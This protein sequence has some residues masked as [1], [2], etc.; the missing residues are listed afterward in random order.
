MRAAV[1]LGFIVLVGCG[2][3]EGD[4]AYAQDSFGM[5]EQAASTTYRYRCRCI[6]ATGSYCTPTGD[7]GTINIALST[8][9][10]TTSIGPAGSRSA[11]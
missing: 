7:W 6:P 10:A 3:M 4:G 9:R 5:A 8:T 11:V 1:W 2:G